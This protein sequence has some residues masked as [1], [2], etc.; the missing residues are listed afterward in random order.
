MVLDLVWNEKY[1][2]QT[3]EECILPERLKTFFGGM[4]ERKELQ[5]FTAAGPAGSGKCLGFDVVLSLKV[6]DEI[7]EDMRLKG[8]I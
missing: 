3:V 2:P 5:S 4:V 8:F 6:S 7:Y 1:R